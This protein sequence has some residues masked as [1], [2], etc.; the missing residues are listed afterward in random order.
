MLATKIRKR[1]LHRLFMYNTWKTPEESNK[2][3][4]RFLM[5]KEAELDHALPNETPSGQTLT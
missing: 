4:S 3:S 5:K 1:Q 2:L